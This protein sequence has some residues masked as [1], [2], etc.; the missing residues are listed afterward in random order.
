MAETTTTVASEEALKELEDVI[1]T[2]EHQ[3]EIDM[4]EDVR[5]KGI[6]SK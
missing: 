4:V 5:H 2:P 3:M 6:E 1:H